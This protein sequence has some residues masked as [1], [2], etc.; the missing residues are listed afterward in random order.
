MGYTIVR[1]RFAAYNINDLDEIYIH[2]ITMQNLLIRKMEKLSARGIT[3]TRSTF[4]IPETSSHI[5][6][7]FP[8]Q[9]S[10]SSNLEPGKSFF[11]KQPHAISRA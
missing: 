2:T 1:I 5:L 11:P 9:L 10:L 7:T 4:L 8:A 6:Y 3:K